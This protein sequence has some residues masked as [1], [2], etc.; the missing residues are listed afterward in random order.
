MNYERD[1]DAEGRPQLFGP[2]FFTALGEQLGLILQPIKAAVDIFVI[3]DADL[4]SEN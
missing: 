4:P 3:D 2:Y 1:T